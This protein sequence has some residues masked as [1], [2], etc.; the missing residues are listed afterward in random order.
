MSKAGKNIKSIIVTVADESLDK[1]DG[2]A[3]QLKANGMNV[4]QILPSTGV[5][6]GLCSASKLNGLEKVKGVMSVE[7]ETTSHLPPPDSTLQ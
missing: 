3:K 1:I 4:K 6:T 7:E 5:I 2:V